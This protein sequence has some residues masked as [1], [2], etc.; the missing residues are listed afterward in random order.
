MCKKLA[1]QEHSRVAIHKFSVCKLSF[2]LESSQ[3]CDSSPMVKWYSP[4]TVLILHLSFVWTRHDWERIPPS[5]SNWIERQSM[6]A[7]PSRGISRWRLLWLTGAWNQW[8]SVHLTLTNRTGTAMVPIQ[9][10]ASPGQV[11]YW[12]K[13]VE[14]L[15]YS[16]NFAGKRNSNLR[17]FL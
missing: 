8:D 2:P 4:V 10:A 15:W 3:P 13:F 11:A 1:Y 7:F 16:Q 9:S 5:Y 14:F 6:F 12:L 17:G